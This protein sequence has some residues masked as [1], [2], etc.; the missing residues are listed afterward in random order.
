MIGN[1]SRPAASLANASIDDVPGGY[2]LDLEHPEELA[3]AVRRFLG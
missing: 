1:G 2:Q 3:G